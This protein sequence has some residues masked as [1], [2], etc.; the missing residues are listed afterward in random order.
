M[1]PLPFFAGL[2]FGLISL[3]V[4]GAHIT[5]AEWVRQF[6]RFHRSI[7]PETNYFPTVRQMLQIVD[8]GDVGKINVIVGGTSVLYGVGQHETVMWTVRLQEALGSRFRVLNFAQRAGRANDFGNI[9]A[10]ALLQRGANVIYVADGMPI[11]LSID[12]PSSF[13]R[14]EMVEAG[15]RGYLIPWAPRDAQ[16]GL[17][18]EQPRDMQSEI[19]GAMLD[20][21]LNFN[22][23]WNYVTFN[24]VNLTWAP[25]LSFAPLAP[26]TSLY[27]DEPL[28]DQYATL[29]YRSPEAK[30]VAIARRWTMANDD[31]RWPL[32]IDLT[33]AGFPPPLRRATVAVINLFSPRYLKLLS[34][35]EQ[36]GF[37]ATAERHVAELRRMGFARTVILATAFNEDDYV[38]RVHL[39]VSGGDKMATAIAPLVRSLAQELG[40][41]P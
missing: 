34:P 24:F 6:T 21:A 12:F 3:S 39:T 36:A 27:D 14:R 22:D 1:K 18:R 26:R 32:M 29:R 16:L 17:R 41:L 9:A 23:L 2:L 13:Y 15:Q 7:N 20:R 38:D 30:E 4:V 40:Y 8:G 10:E 25:L 37:L 35:A 11:E 28:P 5:S 31:P 33:E 19:L